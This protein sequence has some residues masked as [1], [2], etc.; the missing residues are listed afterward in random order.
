MIFKFLYIDENV[1][2]QSLTKTS[3]SN[4]K[5]AEMLPPLN[6]IKAASLYLD[7]HSV[8]FILIDPNFSNENGYAFIQKNITKHRIILHSSRIKD[9]VK[10]FDL[11]VFDFIPKPF[12]IDR[13]NKSIQRL[14]NQTYLQ[15]KQT[16]LIP[17]PYLEVRCNLMTERILHDDIHYIEAMGDYVKIV[18]AQRKYIVLMSMKKINTLLPNQLFYRSHKSFIINSKKIVNYTGKEII[19]KHK[20]IPLSRFRKEGFKELILKIS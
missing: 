15:E 5:E 11:G 6:S 18:T 4:H 14:K 10:G 7:K 1:N 16:I 8:D 13:F 9:A 19:L 20:K 3:I 2:L 12:D 17:K